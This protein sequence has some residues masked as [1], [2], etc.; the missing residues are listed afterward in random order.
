[1]VAQTPRFVAKFKLLEENQ[2]SPA[3]AVGYDGIGYGSYTADLGIWNR[4][5]KG[6]YTA[7]TKEFS[8]IGVWQFTVGLGRADSSS[9]DALRDV[10]PFGGMMMAISRELVVNLEYDDW[11]K[12]SGSILSAGVGWNFDSG[13]KVEFD[14]RDLVTGQPVERTFKIDYSNAI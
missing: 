3:W 13:V 8:G 1:M 10:V 7:V 5:Q 11:F 12:N 4:K 14:F 9:F 2:E 6:F